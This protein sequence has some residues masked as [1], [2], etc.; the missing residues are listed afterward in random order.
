MSNTYKTPLTGIDLKDYQEAV[1]KAS[2]N[3][4]IHPF[5]DNCAEMSSAEIRKYV[6]DDE[7]TEH[8]NHT[9]CDVLAEIKTMADFAFS[10]HKEQSVKLEQ[11]KSEGYVVVGRVSGKENDMKFV[12]AASQEEAEGQFS[13]YLKAEYQSG[14]DVDIFIEFCIETNDKQFTLENTTLSTTNKIIEDDD[15]SP[16]LMAM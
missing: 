3:F 16:H 13:D 8:E 12:S 10:F 6:E 1:I 2:G 14:D 11:S 5:P 4:L 9:T 7:S 15:D